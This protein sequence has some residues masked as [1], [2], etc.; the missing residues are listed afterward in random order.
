MNGITETPTRAERY[1]HWVVR[2]R[3]MVLIVS[4]IAA[5]LFACKTNSTQLK[6]RR[7][8]SFDRHLLKTPRRLL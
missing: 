2:Q 1:A 3:W 7:E 6:T 4:L 8:A 5:L